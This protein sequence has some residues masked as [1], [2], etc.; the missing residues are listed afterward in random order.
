MEVLDKSNLDL[1]P[2][3]NYTFHEWRDM[4]LNKREV[5]K[6]PTRCFPTKYD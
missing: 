5:M 1:P 4:D 2:P 6:L 3:H